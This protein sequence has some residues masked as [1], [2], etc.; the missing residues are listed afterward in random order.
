[1]NDRL[2]KTIL[3]DCKKYWEFDNNI[4]YKV[5][6]K[7]EE[8]RLFV[9]FKTRNAHVNGFGLQALMAYGLTDIDIEAISNKECRI[10]LE[11]N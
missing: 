3:D 2:I 5:E 7:D 8:T 10:E 9:F 4:D 11:F 1:M 6:R